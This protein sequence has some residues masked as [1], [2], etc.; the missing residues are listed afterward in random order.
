MRGPMDVEVEVDG[1]APGDLRVA[2]LLVSAEERLIE[3]PVEA[4]TGASSCGGV[5]GAGSGARSRF[6]LDLGKVGAN[7]AR[8]VFALGVTEAA[9]AKG[10]HTGTI[11][12]GAATLRRG[13]EVIACYGFRGGDFN[14]EA[15]LSVIE[16]YRKDGWRV[17]ASGTGFVGGYPSLLSRYGSTMPGAGA[18][19]L[20][21]PSRPPPPTPSH[22]APRSGTTAVALPASWPGQKDPAVPAGLIPAVGLVVVDTPKGPATGTGFMVGP[23][24][25]FVTCAHV[26]DD[27]RRVMFG[28]EGAQQLRSAT[29]LKMDSASDLALLHVDDRDGAPDWLLLAPPDFNPTLGENLGLL[30]YPLG[31]NLGIN[32]TY[33]QGVI[34]SVR[35]INEISVLQVDTGAAPGSSG[36]PVFRRSDG[37]VVGVLSSGLSQTNGMLVN[38]AIDIRR[39]WQL[40][41]V[42]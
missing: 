11:K 26:V 30:G 24:G 17:M 12:S 14:R 8:I 23:G 25:C 19:P 42:S 2:A 3:A 4:N 5:V 39:L 29:I 32:L 27:A 21:L 7:I 1:L 10:A 28:P 33:S 9:R 15:A 35:R 41:W 20:P 38:F 34:N 22:G 31:G 13:S 18:G 6:T 16:V 37:R 36:G 40:G